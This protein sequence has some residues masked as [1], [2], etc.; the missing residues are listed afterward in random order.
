M[1]QAGRLLTIVVVYR[2]RG[3]C[4][5]LLLHTAG[6]A[7]AYHQLVESDTEVLEEIV[8]AWVVGAGVVGRVA[9]Y[10]LVDVCAAGT[11]DTEATVDV[12][13]CFAS[14]VEV[15]HCSHTVDIGVN[16]L[17]ANSQVD[18]GNFGVPL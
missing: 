3:A 17:G 8:E 15:G 9:V 18:V 4:L 16:I 11:E 7:P 6:G 5:P 1:A 10:T 12:C 2:R 13:V 14:L